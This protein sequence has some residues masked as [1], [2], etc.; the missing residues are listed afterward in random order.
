MK[1]KSLFLTIL[2][3]LLNSCD[4]DKSSEWDIYALYAQKIEGSSKLLYKYNAWGGRDSHKYGFIIIDSTQTFKVDLEKTLPFIKIN[5]IPSKKLISGIKSECNNDCVDEYFT[6]APIYIPLKIEKLKSEGINIKNIVYQYRGLGEKDKGLKG[7]FIFEKFVETND[8]IYFFNLDDI[9]SVH[10]KHLYE[11]KLK[12]GEVYLSENKTGEIT[13][14]VINQTT[15]YPLNNEIN[16][17][18]TY[19]L[20][21]KNKIKS[22]D[23][24][25]RGIFKEVKITK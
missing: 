7:D 3:I 8:S 18:F 9:Q 14:I 10:K 11:L 19:F 5:E 13:Q 2:T 17:T 20:R 25:D 6:T 22:S 15:L 16:E 1:L 24:S 12:K 23:F 21:P 4:L